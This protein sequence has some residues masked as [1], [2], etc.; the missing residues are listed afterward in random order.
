MRTASSRVARRIGWGGRVESRVVD[1]EEDKTAGKVEREAG[2]SAL[3]AR[4]VCPSLLLIQNE[5]PGRVF[6]LT[7]DVTL[8]GRNPDCDITL[9]VE[10]VSRRH[11]RSFATAKR[12]SWRTWTVAISPSSTA[13]DCYRSYRWS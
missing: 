3:D 4:K 2:M 7:R 13:S 11:G 12:C 5:T 8:I 6:E 1:D 9:A 10:A